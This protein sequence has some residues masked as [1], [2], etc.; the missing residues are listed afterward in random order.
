MQVL[1]QSVR[2]RFFSIFTAL[3]DEHYVGETRGMGPD[4]VY[5]VIQAVDG[6]KDPRSEYRNERERE[7]VGL[8]MFHLSLLWF[9][10]L[11]ICFALLERLMTDNGSESF[12]V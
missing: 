1:P 4:F 6:E 7:R 10:N 5:G 8:R 2:Q 12:C 11:L 9:R 3:F